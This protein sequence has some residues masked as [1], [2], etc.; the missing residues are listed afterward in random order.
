VEGDHVGSFAR[1]LARSTFPV[2][3]GGATTLTGT[4]QG[5][6]TLVLRIFLE[7]YLIAWRRQ[8]AWGAPITD[9]K[10]P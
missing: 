9:Q 10:M 4:E 2:T 1:L 3:V 6:L 8:V 5:G 7:S